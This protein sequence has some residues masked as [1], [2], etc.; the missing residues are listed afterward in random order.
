MPQPEF[1]TA[2]E[3]QMQF[4]ANGMKWPYQRVLDFL[5]KHGIAKRYTGKGSYVV[6]TE[7]LQKAITELK[8]V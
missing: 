1:V 3:A 5:K 6:A 7:D 2:S 8:G 4:V